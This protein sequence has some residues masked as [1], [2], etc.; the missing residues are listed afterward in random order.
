GA[1]GARMTGG[2]FGG[3]VIAL[4]EESALEACTAAVRA[5]FA[6]HGFFAPECWTATAA[7]GARRAGHAPA[8]GRH[9]P[10]GHGNP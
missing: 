2:G 5:A 7:A 4:V 8:A 9:V 6:E 3:C 10:A 1:A